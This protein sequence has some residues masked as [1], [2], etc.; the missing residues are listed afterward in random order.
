MIRHLFSEEISQGRL[1]RIV[2][3]CEKSGF[4]ETRVSVFGAGW[5]CFLTYS[6]GK[7]SQRIFPKMGQT[8]IVV[9]VHLSI[10]TKRMLVQSDVMRLGRS[11]P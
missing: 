8:G 4:C 2:S 11:S 7:F 9:T 5:S 6:I 3:C 1:S 10:A